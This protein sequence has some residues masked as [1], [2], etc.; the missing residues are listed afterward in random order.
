MTRIQTSAKIEKEE[1]VAEK[2]TYDSH[3]GPDPQQAS[4]RQ[5]G[6]DHDVVVTRLR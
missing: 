3:V 2:N 4:R 6:G 1:K 5:H